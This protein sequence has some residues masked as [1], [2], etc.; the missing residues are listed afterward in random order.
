MTRTMR[1]RPRHKALII[2]TTAASIAGSTAAAGP[3]RASTTGAMAACTAAQAA[4]Y[5]VAPAVIAGNVGGS[6]PGG[7]NP[8]NVLYPGDVFRIL[9][10]DY[11]QVKIGSWP[12][13]PSY[14]PNGNGVA[15]PSNSNWPFPGLSEY[16]A[17][18][19]FNNN[20]GGWVGAPTQATAYAACTV[21]NGPPVRL[22]FYVNDNNPGDNSGNWW[23]SFYQYYPETH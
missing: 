12:W 23:L 20:P 17:V 1:T 5:S 14:G 8:A 18:L 9:Y 15:A 10:T 11:P 4:D 3:A 16:S 21:W 7:A 6:V 13:D 22:L 19:R 2:L